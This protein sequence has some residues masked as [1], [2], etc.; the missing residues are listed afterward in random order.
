VRR[1]GAPNG[2]RGGCAPH[3]YFGI[4]VESFS[5]I[6][7]DQRLEQRFGELA[8]HDWTWRKARQ[9]DEDVTVNP[10]GV[11]VAEEAGRMLG[12]VST[13][14]DREAAKGRIPNLAVDAAARGRGLGRKLIQHALDYLRRE[15]MA[16]VMIETMENNAIGQRLYPSFGFEEVGRQIHYALKL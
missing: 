12:F 1:E 5:G 16:V 8:G 13:R 11:F 4:R 10:A 6:A 7:I 14:V 2:S 9:I 15:G 3:S